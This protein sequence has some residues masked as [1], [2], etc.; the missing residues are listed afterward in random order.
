MCFFWLENSLQINYCLF[1][2]YDSRHC[3][4]WKVNVCYVTLK[5]QFPDTLHLMQPHCYIAERIR[6]KRQTTIK[7]KIPIQFAT[8]E[9]P[10][11]EKK[12]FSVFLKSFRPTRLRVVLVRRSKEDYE[13]YWLP[14]HN[15]LLS[16]KTEMVGQRLSNLLPLAWPLC[17]LLITMFLSIDS[18]PLAVDITVQILDSVMLY[19]FTNYSSAPTWF[20]LIFC[21]FRWH[22]GH[23]DEVRL[24]YKL[25]LGVLVFAKI[26]QAA[27]LNT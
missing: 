11:F 20:A 3:G 6:G 12:Y 27:S 10:K 7:F 13:D 2:L 5:V 16:A 4:Y 22:L 1:V 8:H 21:A 24:A 26:K 19:M 14:A 23:S 9:T 18:I 15:S 25:T 17:R